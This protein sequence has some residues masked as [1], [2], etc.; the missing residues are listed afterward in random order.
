MST[1][2][3]RSLVCSRARPELHKTGQALSNYFREFSTTQS[4]ADDAAPSGN[5][6]SSNTGRGNAVRQR[7]RAAASAI[8]NM[9]RS[10]G[11][12]PNGAGQAPNSGWRGGRGG[13]RG[14]T[15]APGGGGAPRVL[16]VR[17]LPRGGFRGRGRG[18]QPGG[19]R[20]GGQ[21]G[22]GRGGMGGRG[23]F[24]GGSR[25]GSSGGVGGR[26]GGGARRGGGDGEGGRGGLREGG[27]R[28]AE[29]EV[30]PF[31][32][33]DEVEAAYD[34]ELR[35]GSTREYQP[36][37][38]ADSL[39]EHGPAAPTSAASRRATVLGSLNAMGGGTGD[40]VG[41]STG[42][43][44][45]A[46]EG[47]VQDDGLAF[48]ANR[49]SKAL[50]EE[51]LQAKKREQQQ[52]EGGDEAAAEGVATQPVFT[53]ASDAVKQAIV[54]VAIEGKHETPV[55]ATD[56]Y[57]VVR[58]QQL[59]TRGYSA[60]AMAKFQAKLQSLVR[61]PKAAGGAAGKSAAAPKKTT[62]GKGKAAKA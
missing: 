58:S 59:H 32:H 20:F 5:S 51:H 25:G 61:T 48:F 43:L 28:Q 38:D 10:R 62:K 4:L 12:S 22:G 54:D 49:E 37:L 13:G 30:N 34:K 50:V 1:P 14:G 57:G 27:R 47:R 55:F 36:K 31:A 26:S 3:F 53:P 11:P 21:S 15:A 17:S 40:A 24:G 33:M 56:V 29:E 16:D 46:V 6:S 19:N 39:L 44:P 18:G 8:N 45:S 52:S 9:V 35:F 7:G 23:G 2:T 41:S 42:Y 60:A